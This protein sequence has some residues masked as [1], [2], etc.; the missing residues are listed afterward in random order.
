M[1]GLTNALPILPAEL[2]DMI[3]GWVSKIGARHDLLALSLT[4]RHFAHYIQPIL[5]EKISFSTLNARPTVFRGL[6]EAKPAL[7]LLVK[8][9]TLTRSVVRQ[10]AM[11]NVLRRM[12]NVERLVFPGGLSD[13]PE[14]DERFEYAHRKTWS[15]TLPYTDPWNLKSEH[16]ETIGQHLP[17]LKE[18]VFRDLREFPL[19]MILS[20]TPT[21]FHL[22]LAC[23]GRPGKFH[24]PK[25]VKSFRWRLDTSYLSRYSGTT[26]LI[27]SGLTHLELVL[28]IP[29]F[30]LPNPP[31]VHQPSYEY[32]TSLQ[33]LTLEILHDEMAQGNVAEETLPFFLSTLETIPKTAPLTNLAIILREFNL[34]HRIRPAYGD[35]DEDDTWGRIDEALMKVRTAAMRRPIPV[36]KFQV[37]VLGFICEVDKLRDDLAALDA[38]TDIEVMVDSCWHV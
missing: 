36:K 17:K 19:E 13:I 25:H 14:W 30:Q 16:L 37:Q 28:R 27:G 8:D 7:V 15:W 10:K 23:I 20:H 22:E 31:T 9:V 18:L 33:S 1:L 6:I 3:S 26:Q 2:L 29:Y 24:L 21:L 34:Y 4:S 11:L 38:D 12:H 32:L 5:F 35:G